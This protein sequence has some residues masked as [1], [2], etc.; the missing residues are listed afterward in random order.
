VNNLSPC[1]DRFVRTSFRSL[2]AFPAAVLVFLCVDPASGRQAPPPCQACAEWNQPQTPFHIFANTYYVGPRGLSVIL[3]TSDQGHV[4]I[5]AALPESAAAIASSV[6][7]LGF[8]VED[9]RLILN[10]HVHFDHAGGMAELQR[11]SGATVMATPWSASVL[12]S[13]VVPRSDPQFGL[14][15]PIARVQKI[16]M[17]VDG[18]TLR[19]GSL[20]VTAHETPGH[21]P[22]GTSWTWRSCEGAVCV[23]FVYADSLTAVSA[24]GFLFTNSREYPHAVADFERS[25]RTLETVACGILLTP[26]PEASGLW[27]RLERRDKER[28]A[29]AMI[30]PAGCSRYVDGARGRFRKRVSIEAS[31]P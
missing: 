2:A 11:M 22:G 18:E 5:D 15:P 26:H 29:D 4:L 7:A 8:K 6:R 31:A 19:V 27:Q 30:D 23:D 10:S 13:G 17:V 24:D 9:I 20:A 21:T 14:A 16:G 3:V 1:E 25:F 12:T 28:I